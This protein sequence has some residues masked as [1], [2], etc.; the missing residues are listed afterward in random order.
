[1]NGRGL[2]QN[3]VLIYQKDQLEQAGQMNCL[4]LVDLPSFE[5][6]FVRGRIHQIIDF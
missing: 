1:M 2:L 5:I 4:G 6:S 3:R